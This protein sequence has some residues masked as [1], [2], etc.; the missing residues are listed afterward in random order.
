MDLS[1]T[2]V[3]L[4]M[5]LISTSRAS[6]S[7]A[8]GEGLEEVAQPLGL[9]GVAAMEEV[10]VRSPLGRGVRLGLGFRVEREVWLGQLGVSSLVCVAPL[11]TPP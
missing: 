7:Q 9:G 3:V 1:N 4:V 11:P 6:P 8:R 5:M 2:M 10:V